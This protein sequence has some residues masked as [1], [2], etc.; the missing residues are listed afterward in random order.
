MGGGDKHPVINFNGAFTQISCRRTRETCRPPETGVLESRGIQRTESTVTWRWGK[1]HPLDYELSDKYKF[2][3]SVNRARSS[4]KE[5]TQAASHM[6][7]HGLFVYSHRAALTAPRNDENGTEAWLSIFTVV[8]SF[9][10]GQRREV[11]FSVERRARCIVW[12]WHCMAPETGKIL[13]TPYLIIDLVLKIVK[14]WPCSGSLAYSPKIPHH[15]T[16][17][18]N[19]MHELKNVIGRI[20]LRQRPGPKGTQW[21]N[22]NLHN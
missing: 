19:R 22:W 2:R 18:R 17:C 3:V 5:Y 14:M 20:P 4:F 21:K 7:R 6:A 15:I 11:V 13:G 1:E 9:F 12:F 8:Y 10:V 16:R